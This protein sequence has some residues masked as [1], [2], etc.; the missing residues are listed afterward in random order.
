[1]A[2]RPRVF[3]RGLFYD[4][5]VRSN[6]RQRTFLGDQDYQ[7]YLERLA[8]YQRRYGV[9]I[10][11]YCLVPNHVFCWRPLVSLWQS[12]CRDCSNLTLSTSTGFTTKLAI[13]FKGDTRLSSVRKTN[14]FWS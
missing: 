7:A 11:A 9:V 13:C 5:I 6:Q 14:I 10:Y 8:R 3:G 2:R 4:V 1:M 12:S